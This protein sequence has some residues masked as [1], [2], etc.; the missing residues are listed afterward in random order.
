M[1][2]S[3]DH[4]F[5]DAVTRCGLGIRTACL[6]TFGNNEKG[7]MSEDKFKIYIMNSILPLFPDA[8]N[9][10]DK[11]VQLKMD[12]GPAQNNDNLLVKLKSHVFYRLTS[13]PR[14]THLIKEMDVW[15]GK[16][17]HGFYNNLDF[18]TNAYLTHNK[19][20]LEPDRD[21]EICL[22]A[23]GNVGLRILMYAPSQESIS[24]MR[25]C[26]TRSP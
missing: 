25:T 22:N 12:M 26:A 1:C 10:P 4:R 9:I 23:I 17:K 7:G 18:V 21:H 11:I 16:F 15:L 6:V 19:A 20:I 2:L 3:S 14:T 8:R 13:V 5:H 24:K